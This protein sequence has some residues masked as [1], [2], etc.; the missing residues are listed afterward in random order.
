VVMLEKGEEINEIDESLREWN[1][2]MDADGRVVAGAG[3]KE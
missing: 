1:A 3:S 2:S